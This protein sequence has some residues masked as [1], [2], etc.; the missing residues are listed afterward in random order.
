MSPERIRL[1]TRV[2]NLVII[3]PHFLKRAI[4]RT[5]KVKMRSF[6]LGAGA[7]VSLPGAVAHRETSEDHPAWHRKLNGISASISALTMSIVNPLCMSETH[8]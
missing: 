1:P 4:A 3:L 7:D 2:A 5:W 6:R 8:T